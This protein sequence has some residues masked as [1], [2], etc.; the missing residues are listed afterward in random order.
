MRFIGVASLLFIT[1]ALIC[2]HSPILATNKLKSHKSEEMDPLMHAKVTV[3]NLFPTHNFNTECESAS[4]ALSSEKN[5]LLKRQTMLLENLKRMVFE[6]TG[7]VRDLKVKELKNPEEF[8]T[9]GLFRKLNTIVP[10][11]VGVIKSSLKYTRK[12]LANQVSL[13]TTVIKKF[14][15]EQLKDRKNVKPFQEINGGTLENFKTELYDEGTSLKIEKQDF[16]VT[17]TIKLLGLR[18]ALIEEL[19][20]VR[21]DAE[22]EE[23]H[24]VFTDFT[25]HLLAILENLKTWFK[26][27][28]ETLIDVMQYIYHKV[29]IKA[30]CA[31]FKKKRSKKS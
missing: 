20:K 2:L 15:S 6:K 24:G 8:F 17:L 13:M 7:K 9:E 25:P 19:E 1:F 28:D 16:Q 14:V 31:D 4:L 10:D 30:N 21:N 23:M 22:I 27:Y 3:K 29:E 5:S 11:R 26:L 18:R 12:K